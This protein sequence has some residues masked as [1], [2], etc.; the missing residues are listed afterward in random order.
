[1]PGVPGGTG[2]GTSTYK[3]KIKDC[4]NEMQAQG[5]LE[6]AQ[7]MRCICQGCSLENP[8]V[9]IAMEDYFYFNPRIFLT[10]LVWGSA[11]C[12][13]IIIFI[14]GEAPPLF[15]VGLLFLILPI[16]LILGANDGV[17]KGE[18]ACAECFD[19]RLSELPDDHAT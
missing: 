11:I 6:E 10:P 8:K 16:L 4:L 1:M 3:S 18:R 9:Y 15:I 12:G 2:G 14:A 13:G 19:T 7:L 5:I 17:H